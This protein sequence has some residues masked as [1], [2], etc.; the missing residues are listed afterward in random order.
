MFSTPYIKVCIF[1]RQLLLYHEYFC[2]GTDRGVSVIV[3]VFIFLNF[4]LQGNNQQQ[5]EGDGGSGAQFCQLQP[6]AAQRRAGRAE[7]QHGGLPDR[8]V[9]TQTQFMVCLLHAI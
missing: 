3:P 8:Q 4:I 6:A 9:V 7:Q 1:I 5:G 2:R